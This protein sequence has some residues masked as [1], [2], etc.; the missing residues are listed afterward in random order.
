MNDD[1]PIRGR[2][3]DQLG[4]TKFAEAL[5][6]EIATA[7]GDAGQVLA[8]LGPWGSGKTSV[9]NMVTEVLEERPDV[10]VLRFNPWYFTGT[11]QLVTRFFAE[12]VAQLATRKEKLLK[13]IAD[14]LEGYGRRLE[15]LVS[16]PVIGEVAQTI[17]GGAAVGGA[18]ARRG[19]RHGRGSVEQQRSAIDAALRASSKRLVVVVDDIDRLEPGEVRDIVRLVR[20]VADFPR[21]TYLLA[22]DRGRIERALG[23][24]DSSV[25]RDYL[26]KIVQG[27]HNLPRLRQADLDRLLT[28]SLD[29]AIDGH[30]TGPFDIGYWQNVFGFVVRPL[31]QTPR[32]VRR[33]VNA[34][35][36]ALIRLEDEVNLVDVLALEAVRVLQPEVFELLAV[37]SETLTYTHGGYIGGGDDR[38]QRDAHAAVVERF[39]S[40]GGEH[41]S[42]I[43]ELCRWVFPGSRAFFENNHHGPEWRRT[44][45]RERR[46][47]HPDVLGIYLEAALPAGAVPAAVV[48]AA[49]DHLT[50]AARLQSLLDVLSPG[51]V[52]ELLGRLEDYEDEFPE[53]VSDAVV[54]LMAQS[55]RLREGRS[56]MWDF[57]ADMTLTR[58]VLRLLRRVA[59][60]PAREVI[61][62]RAFD[63]MP[64][65]SARI[66]LL[67]I[68][69]YEPNAGH[70]LVSEG[71]ASRLGQQLRDLIL[72]ASPE[73]LARERELPQLL[74]WALRDDELGSQE[75]VRLVL[76]DDA[77]L[78]RL[79]RSTLSEAFSQTIGEV[80]QRREYRLPWDWLAKLIGP[81]RLDERVDALVK[82]TNPADL[83]ERGRTAIET[84]QRYLSGWR[85]SQW[86]DRE[87]MDD[88]KDS[89]EPDASESA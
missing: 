61:A 76:D 16:V 77:A 6:L 66:Q 20:L 60:E 65:L 67:L 86:I 40:A 73:E 71:E 80:N 33:Y 12:V 10:A 47:A 2:G 22:F 39:I 45:R 87:D 81:D 44:W 30:P 37:S 7:P 50:D 64:S 5:A 59:D 3:E 4:R 68:V 89:P 79:L 83:D 31:I 52:E 42:A 38:A 51:Q 13:G 28:G 82:A 54:V 23:E 63:Q 18:A 19:Q 88:E 75:T 62:A 85:P 21:T 84:A 26:E 9:L 15:P 11:D 69:G 43:R 53:D 49:F 27:V 8:L 35:P 78:F 46:V 32:D 29:E 34:I 24:G 36:A 25:G 72:R 1:R 58:V 57:G 56:G 41:A 48:R 70:E 74:S 17:A 55:D 14:K